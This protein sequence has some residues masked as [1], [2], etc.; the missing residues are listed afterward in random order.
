MIQLKNLK[1]QSNIIQSPMAGCTDLAFRLVARSYGMEFAFLEMVSARALVYHND[2][3]LDLLKS[4][5]EDRP[6][7]AQLVG[8]EPEAMGEAAAIIE[9]MGFSLL[10]INFGCPVPK[11]TGP[12]GGSA[13]LKE[14]ETAKKIFENVVKNVKKIPVTVKMRKGF[15]DPSGKEAVLIAKIAEDHGLS[16]VTVHG[17]TREQGYTGTADWEAIGKVKQAVKIPVFGNGDV[18][19]PEDAKKLLEV[20]GCDGVMIGRGALGNPWI[21]KNIEAALHGGQTPE[22]PTLEDKKKAALQHLELEV[23]TESEKLA[24]L[25]ARKIMCWY[26]RDYPG[27]AQ[28]RDKVNRTNSAQEIRKIVE[29]FYPE[30]FTP[31]KTVS[32]MSSENF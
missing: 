27:S 9:N 30:S 31:D 32:S 26:F 16:A 11:I 2:R 18:T 8:C 22:T 10:D 7:G 24:S 17:R 25:K 23:H 19:G 4:T 1:L 15:S 5:V 6:L 14:P 28:F 3:T 20:S 13:L 29:D 21:Y 12:G